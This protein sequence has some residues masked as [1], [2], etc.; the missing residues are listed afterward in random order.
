M[1][2]RSAVIGAYA[3]NAGQ[4]VAPGLGL[5]LWHTISAGGIAAIVT[6]MAGLFMV[7]G[8]RLSGHRLPLLLLPIT[9][10][11]YAA[12]GAMLGIGI[13]IPLGAF[14]NRL[15]D[16][17]LALTGTSEQTYRIIYDGS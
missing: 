12:P 7:Y 16:A 4:W 8:V 9:A 15:A 3:L 5:A 6:V 11:G 1:L 13:L 10:I 2:F 17:L 14:D